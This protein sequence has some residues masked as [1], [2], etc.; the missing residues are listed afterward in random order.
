M[1]EQEPPEQHAII[2]ADANQSI[3][4]PREMV[5]RGL[6][7]AAKLE[8]KPVVK[9]LQTPLKQCPGSYSP[10][11]ISFS[12]NGQFA[13]ITAWGRHVSGSFHIL[14]NAMDGVR[15]IAMHQEQQQE[16]VY[17]AAVSKNGEFALMGYSD[18]RILG[19]NI[20]N[21]T[22]GI[23]PVDS[24]DSFPQAVTILPIKF[25]PYTSFKDER[26]SA[27]PQK[28]KGDFPDFSV[29]AL[30]I[31]PDERC[32]AECSRHMYIRI[33]DLQSGKEIQKMMVGYLDYYTQIAF[34]E[35]GSQ[36]AAAR[37]VTTTEYGGMLSLITIFDLTGKRKPLMLGGTRIVSATAVTF[38]PDGR[39][40][41]SLED[42]GILTVWDAQD[43]KEL[44]HW[45]H[46]KAREDARDLISS[47]AVSPNMRIEFRNPQVWGLSSVAVSPDGERILSGGGDTCM[48]LWSLD[49]QQLYEYL[50]ST[51]VV[52]VAFTPDG[53]QA[54]SGC[55]D[56]SAY[57]WE[58]P[59]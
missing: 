59:Q 6:D 48:R 37:G 38:S 25:P 31:S 17:S 49:G 53:K 1:S 20:K 12:K 10:A 30:A 8:R 55:W 28:P 14:W 58:L 9:N 34:S 36:L 19:W 56:G 26:G 42:G 29:T 7:L 21:G 24:K 35:D 57:L 32:F 5:K 22:A 27:T 40:V 45:P 18:G 52:R 2:P 44:A 39:K 13:L 11:C 50:H 3:T 47:E 16:F 4:L 51:R 54:L 41:V 15:T 23:Y 46:L 43:G 33:R